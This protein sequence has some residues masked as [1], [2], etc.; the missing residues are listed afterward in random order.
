MFELTLITGLFLGILLSSLFA[1]IGW[2]LCEKKYR[3][4]KIT[5]PEFLKRK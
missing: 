5:I 4:Q 2:F 1:Y 3:L